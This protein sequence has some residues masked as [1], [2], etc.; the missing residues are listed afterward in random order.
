MFRTE[1]QGEQPFEQGSASAI[2]GLGYARVELA[3]KLSKWVRLG[4]ASTAGTTI[5]PVTIRFA[6]NKAGTWGALI[7]ASFLQLGVDW[8]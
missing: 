1:G 6:G 8:E 3:L 5:V 7:L 2:T 4:I